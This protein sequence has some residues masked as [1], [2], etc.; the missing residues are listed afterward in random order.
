M[1]NFLLSVYSKIIEQ[2]KKNFFFK[3]LLIPDEFNFRLIQNGGK[4][5]LNLIKSYVILINLKN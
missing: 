4:I 5:V 1:N 2:S 3:D